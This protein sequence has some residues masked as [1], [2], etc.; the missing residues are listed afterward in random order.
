MGEIIAFRPYA[1]DNGSEIRWTPRQTYERLWVV[2]DTYCPGDFC[3]LF[4]TEVEAETE[5]RRRNTAGAPWNGD[6]PYY[7]INAGWAAQLR[8]DRHPR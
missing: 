7:S 1:N 3:G 8:P 2:A 5:A 6:A 4:E